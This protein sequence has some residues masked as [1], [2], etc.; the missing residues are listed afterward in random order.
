MKSRGKAGEILGERENVTDKDAPYT[1]EYNYLI[2]LENNGTVG[3]DRTTDLR[4][5]KTMVR[6]KIIQ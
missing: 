1:Y 4:I 6:S 5:H 2:L 3:W